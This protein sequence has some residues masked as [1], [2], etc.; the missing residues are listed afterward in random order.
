MSTCVGWP[1]GKELVYLHP[2]LSSTKVNASPRKLLQVDASRHKWVAKRSASWTQVQKLHR[3]PS[4]FGQVL[5]T[6]FRGSQWFWKD[7][8]KF[9]NITHHHQIC[10]V[11]RALDLHMGGLIGSNPSCTTNKGQHEQSTVRKYSSIAFIWV[12]TPLD[13]VWLFTI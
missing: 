9:H 2:N 4:S 7:W 8:T 10:S 11:S 12:V 3:L 6:Y 13:F 1:N 5:Q